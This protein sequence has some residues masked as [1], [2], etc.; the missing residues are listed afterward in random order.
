MAGNLPEYVRYSIYSKL[1][2]HSNEFDIPSYEKDIRNIINNAVKSA[3][4][5]DAF[6]QVGNKELSKSGRVR[7][8]I[9]VHK[10][11]KATVGSSLSHIQQEL[12]YKDKGNIQ[13]SWDEKYR[14]TRPAPVNARQQRILYESE[15][16]NAPASRDTETTRSIKG[17]MLK[18]LGL[19][20]AVVDIARRI[21]S[22][23]LN[24]AVQSSKDMVT[25]HNLGMSY[26]A[27]RSYRITEK[28]HGLKEGTITDAI[29][30]IQNKFGNITSLDEKALEALAVVMGGKIE[31]MAKMG[32]GASNPEAILSAI[33]D[34]F[35]AKANAGYNSIGQY[36]GE[37]Q[38]R[39]E[40]YSYLLKV[41]PQIADIFATM[42]EEQHNINSL[43]RN[44][45]DTFEEWKNLVPTSRGGHDKA[46]QNVTVTVGKEWEQVKSV[47]ETIKQDFEMD[48]APAI[49]GLLR[50][51]KNIRLGMTTSENM[52]LNKANRADNEAEI[53]RVKRLIASYGGGGNEAEQYYIEALQQ[54]IKELENA[55]KGDVK[56]NIANAVRNEEELRVM[57][58]AIAQGRIKGASVTFTDTNGTG[59]LGGKLPTVD[60]LRDDV[61]I[62]DILAILEG[63][64]KF[65]L[66]AERAKYKDSLE[67]AN[68][69]IIKSNTA[70]GNKAMAQSEANIRNLEKERQKELLADA[71]TYAEE[72]I[73]KDKNSPYYVPWG[74][75]RADTIEMGKRNT[76]AKA[77]SIYGTLE[78]STVSEKLAY[79]I[80]QGYVYYP[81]TSI[82][83]IRKTSNIPALDPNKLNS[84]ELVSTNEKIRMKQEA[85]LNAEDK[86]EL[87]SYDEESFLYWLY[88]N[89]ASWFN[90]NIE[91][92]EFERVKEEARKGNRLASL[93]MVYK[94]EENWL[95][96]VPE[97]Y[98]GVG[99][100]YGIN[101]INENGETTHRIVLEIGT[102][103]NKKVIEVGSFLG[104]ESYEGYLGKLIFS[105]NAEGG[106]DYTVSMGD[107]PSETRANE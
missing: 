51:I 29:S 33:L 91:G 9:Y 5:K 16:A 22:S 62:E 66:D 35:N 15:Q 46:D 80:A 31:D 72:K 32:I 57:A 45:A 101:D 4:P 81:E 106:V 78:G 1:D 8:D 36:V 75:K 99:S 47:L 21:L 68:N 39:R 93:F 64:N 53:S 82:G 58:N 6:F 92:L 60:L 87:L 65:D 104:M 88:A 79:A 2:P 25:A 3:L 24:F 76:V 56:G 94:D 63:Y 71:N 10:E 14:V 26:E 67:K 19:L 23:I 28:A 84:I 48:F 85:L 52:E 42:Q 83:G 20:T 89:N 13:G 30:D 74:L 96:Q 11:D 77:E 95:P 40:L 34:E 17:S 38:A 98:E 70:I 102:G 107:T 59:V 44:Q 73:L 7:W 86:Q 90:Q 50:G 12:V 18:V 41:S 69:K 49:I 54:Y 55:N 37:Q 97:T 100:L 43:F 27:V 105:Q 61:S 103:N